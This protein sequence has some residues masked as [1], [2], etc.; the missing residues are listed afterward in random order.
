[1][2]SPG[3]RGSDELEVSERI[4]GN[5][6]I[7]KGKGKAKE[8]IGSKRFTRGSQKHENRALHDRTVPPYDLAFCQ[9]AARS[10]V[11]TTRPRR[12]KVKAAIFVDR[13][14]ARYTTQPRG[15]A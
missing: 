1:M 12:C 9:M 14:T 5:E 10:R 13:A 7:E 3:V 2:S 6:W 15:T 8:G 11:F 4:E